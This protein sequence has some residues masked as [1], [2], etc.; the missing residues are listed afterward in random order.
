M[1]ARL[2]LVTAGRSALRFWRE[3]ST[4]LVALPFYVI[5]VAVLSGVW[6]VAVDVS[7]GELAGYSATALTWYIAVSEASMLSINHRLID[8]AGGAIGSGAVSVELLRPAS[9]VGVRMATEFGLALTKL[10]CLGAAAV[11]FCVLTVGRP[12]DPIALL[13]AVPS[14]VLAVAANVAAQHAFAAS[15]FWVRDAQVAWFLYQK[16]VFVLGGMLIPIEVFPSWLETVARFSPFSAMAY[17]PAR[18][19]S[20]HVEPGVLAGQVGWVVVLVGAAVAMFARGE[21]RMLAVGG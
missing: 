9:V 14:A 15:A 19:A 3:R 5:V 6:R 4:L 11:G 2:F 18:L 21:R 17:A 20:G 7:G 8:E 10:V 13:L 12:P 1:T 16:L